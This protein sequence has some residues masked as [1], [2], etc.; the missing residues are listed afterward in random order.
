[1]SLVTAR[2][3]DGTGA[4]R[5]MLLG[6]VLSERLNPN[7]ATDTTNTNRALVA[8][9]LNLK[10]IVR[11]PAGVS[12][13]NIDSAANIVAGFQ[14][15]NGNITP[16]TNFFFKFVNISANALTVQ[17]AAANTG[18]TVVRGNV[19]ANSSKDYLV[20]FVSTAPVQTFACTTTNA[21]AVLGGLTA[22]QCALLQPG[23][24]VTNAVANQQGNTIIGINPQA[25]TV[26]MSGNSNA[27]N[28]APGVAVTFSP[29]ITF[30]GM[31]V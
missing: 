26:T 13:E 17:A 30:T 6:D 25:G 8:A 2:V 21:S 14:P 24:V 9:D 20:T 22:A 16:G 23:M 11:N 1:M 18:I 19:P 29:T 4:P 3:D 10:Y 27:T 15:P 28:G 12:N 31:S 5:A 7:L